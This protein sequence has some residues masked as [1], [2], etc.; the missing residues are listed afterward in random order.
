MLNLLNQKFKSEGSKKYS[1]KNKYFIIFLAM[2]S[3]STYKN[4]SIISCN[5]NLFYNI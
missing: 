3:N 2:S 4:V 1:K 5:K